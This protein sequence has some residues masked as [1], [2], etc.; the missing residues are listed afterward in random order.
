MYNN[1]DYRTVYVG[2]DEGEIELCRFIKNGW[3]T[4]V[5]KRKRVH[6]KDNM[7]VVFKDHKSSH[8]DSKFYIENN[9]QKM[10]KVF[11]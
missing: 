3:T 1:I 6:L 8:E 7:V 5:D 2:D 10:Q 4:V 11:Q 9:V